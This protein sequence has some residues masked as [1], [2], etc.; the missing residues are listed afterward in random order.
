VNKVV[1][2]E[3]MEEVINAYREWTDPPKDEPP[4][5]SNGRPA[6]DATHCDREK[7]TP[8]DL[9]DVLSALWSVRPQVAVDRDSWRDIGMACKE[10]GECLLEHWL[11][12]SRTHCPEK[13]E[14]AEARRQWASFK[15]AG[16]IGPGTLFHHAKKNGWRFPNPMAGV[17]LSHGSSNGQAP[18]PAAG[19][20]HRSKGYFIFRGGP[21]S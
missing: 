11:L 3:M 13:Y 5:D 6:D 10:C 8:P 21:L 19:P 12:W 7:K 15:P 14:E 1:T 16:G 2:R 4:P 17:K 20:V 18:T 9:A